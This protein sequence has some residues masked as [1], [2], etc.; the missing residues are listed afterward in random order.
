MRGGILSIVFL[1][2]VGIILAN[3]IVNAGS[4]KTVLDSLGSI[5][6]TSVNGL[7]AKPSTS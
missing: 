2:V 3:I 1:I 6:K 5:W 7:L 4:T